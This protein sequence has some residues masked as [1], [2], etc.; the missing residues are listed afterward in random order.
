MIDSI[1]LLKHEGVLSFEEIVEVTKTAVG[2]GIT[3]VRLTG[4]DCQRCNR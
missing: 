3:K 2:M 4:A 1:E